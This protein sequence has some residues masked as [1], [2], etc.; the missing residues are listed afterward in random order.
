MLE[1]ICTLT[2][3]TPLVGV[4]ALVQGEQVAIFRLKDGNVYAVSNYDPF[5]Q[6][7]VIARGITGNLKGYDVVASPIYKQHFDLKTGLCLEDETVSLK[8]YQVTVDGDNVLIAH[9]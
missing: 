8:T 3:L 6:A 2:D 7:N 5:S 9:H 1:K 4:P